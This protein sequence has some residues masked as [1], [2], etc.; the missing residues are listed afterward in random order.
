MKLN[1]SLISALI[2][3]PALMQAAAPQPN[4]VHIFSVEEA[5]G[6]RAVCFQHEIDHL[7]GILF[8]DRLSRLKRTLYVKRR[9]KQLL[10]EQDL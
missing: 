10:A 4:I 5:D 8:I 1:K 9:K 6:L 3:V 7:D 2:V